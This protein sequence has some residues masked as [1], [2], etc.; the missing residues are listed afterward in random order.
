M[1][2]THTYA[3]TGVTV[4]LMN[5]NDIDH[6]TI[7]FRRDGTVMTAWRG[8]RRFGPV[9]A[10][11]VARQARGFYVQ[12][13][14]PPEALE[15]QHWPLHTAIYHHVDGITLEVGDWPPRISYADMAAKAATTEDRRASAIAALERAIA[16]GPV[17]VL[18]PRRPPSSR[19]RR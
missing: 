11:A 3:D 7:T 8:T 5:R 2:I 18:D 17:T 12:M 15:Q 4:R 1:T 19:A 16:E 9:A 13:E 10:Q 6:A 14:A